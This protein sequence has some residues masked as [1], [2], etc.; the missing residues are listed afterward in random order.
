MRKLIEHYITL[1]YIHIDKEKNSKLFLNH[2]KIDLKNYLEL[3][4]KN[5]YNVEFNEF[6][7]V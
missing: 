5:N 3:A 2:A 1:K 6:L 4:K 7:R